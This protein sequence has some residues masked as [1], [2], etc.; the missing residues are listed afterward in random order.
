[1]YNNG[2]AKSIWEPSI[3]SR[4]AKSADLPDNLNRPYRKK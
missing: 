3:P 1:M 2:G 4:E